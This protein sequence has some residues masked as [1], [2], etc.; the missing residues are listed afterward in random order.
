M[1]TKVI[2]KNHICKYTFVKLCLH[3]EFNDLQMFVK[4][5]LTNVY[6][7]IYSFSVTLNEYHNAL[8]NRL[9][10]ISII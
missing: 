6:V 5:L 1:F 10:Y 3:L 8:Y 7:Y 4:R 9:L 2:N